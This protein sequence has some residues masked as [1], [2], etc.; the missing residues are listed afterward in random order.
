MPDNQRTLEGWK[1]IAGHFRV[2]IRTVQQWEAERG[3]PVQ[4][5]AGG[6]GRVW[7]EVGELDAWRAKQVS[8]P[9]VALTARP[10]WVA[11]AAILVAAAAVVI[12]VAA[13]QGSSAAADA[14]HD[15]RQIVARDAN[16]R[17]VWT[18]S[19]G[20]L[21]PAP[22]GATANPKPILVDLDGDGRVEVLAYNPSEPGS[23][24]ENGV[25][26][27]DSR[28]RILWRFQPG[29][30]VRTTQ[31]LF[32]PPYHVFK[33]EPFRS[34]EGGPWR[35]GVISNHHLYFPSQ[36]AVLDERGRLLREYWHAGHLH[37]LAAGDLDRDG[38][39]ELYAA[40]LSNGHRNAV[41]IALD[42]ERMEGAGWEESDDYRFQSM[43][44]GVEIVRWLTPRTQ[45]S[46]RLMKYNFNRSISRTGDQL[47]I[48]SLEYDYAPQLAL[49]LT[50]GPRLSSP[51]WGPCDCF[52]SGLQQAKASGVAD[53]ENVESAMRGAVG[54]RDV[55]YLRQETARSRMSERPATQ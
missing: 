39:P 47:L 28:G 21:R 1:E 13:W 38:K 46:K 34:R 9:P 41:A 36:V 49:C 33:I 54:F 17:V 4:R 27:F 53:V 5:M 19:F 52:V 42:P 2:S 22:F 15:G 8:P 20:N 37:D 32:E 18:H 12:G 30:A 40:G 7:A 11:I 51:Q 23:A 26:C 50:F 24:A 16:G 55:T 25:F 31:G 14:V 45:I 48:V 29:K 44:P 6:R 10:V 35:I 3:L 43:R